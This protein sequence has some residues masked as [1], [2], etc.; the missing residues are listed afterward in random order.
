MPPKFKIPSAS[1]PMVD[2]AAFPVLTEEGF[3]LHH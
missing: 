3:R 1:S 2:L